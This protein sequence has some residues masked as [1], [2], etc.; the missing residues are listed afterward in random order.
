MTEE[1][2]SALE[3]ISVEA[4]KTENQNEKRNRNSIS[5]NHKTTAKGINTYNRN[6]RMK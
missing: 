4:S 3:N 1:R 5:K 6:V 2:I